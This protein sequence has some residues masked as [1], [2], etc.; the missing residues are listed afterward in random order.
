MSRMALMHIIMHLTGTHPCLGQCFS[1]RLPPTSTHS[2]LALPAPLHTFISVVLSFTSTVSGCSLGTRLT[3]GYQRCFQALPCHIVQGLLSIL[4]IFLLSRT[5][6]VCAS[7]HS[8]YAVVIEVA[9]RLEK[10]Q[11]SGIIHLTALLET[12]VV[13]YT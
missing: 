11:V 10:D 2:C 4:V 6:W 13:L 3:P 5:L 7:V 12:L 8:T 9:G 1:M